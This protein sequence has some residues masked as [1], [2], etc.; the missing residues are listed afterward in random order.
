MVCSI[1]GDVLFLPQILLSVKWT[2]QL[3]T[4]LLTKWKTRTAV[5]PTRPRVSDWLKGDSSTL[6]CPTLLF[7][8]NLVFPIVSLVLIICREAYMDSSLSCSAFLDCIDRPFS[9]S[10]GKFCDQYSSSGAYYCDNPCMWKTAEETRG[11][12]WFSIKQICI[13][14]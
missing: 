6:G 11:S 7:K 10:R 5:E 13:C 3:L 9:A 12:W 1:C 2:Q 8:Q 4:F 14:R